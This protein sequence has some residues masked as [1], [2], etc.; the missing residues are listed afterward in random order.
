M[1][2]ER[3]ESVVLLVPAASRDRFVP[4]LY[5]EREIHLEEFVNADDAWSRRFHSPDDDISPVEVQISRL[6]GALEFLREMHKPASDFLEGL[7]PVRIL[8]THQ[9]IEEAVREV[10]PENL[11][12]ECYRLRSALEEAQEERIRLLGERD[13]LYELEF[14]TVR[15]DHLRNLRHLSFHLVTATGP[16]QKTFIDDIRLSGDIHVE[17]VAGV[18][19]SVTYVI[20]APLSRMDVIREVII[21]YALHEYVLPPVEGTIEHELVSINR[22]I[23]LATVHE[24]KIRAEAVKLSKQWSSRADLALGWWESERNRILQQDRMASS[25]HV[26]ALRGYMRA[27]HCERFQ[28]RMAEFFPEAELEVQP[29]PGNEDP[30]VSVTWNKF[31]RPAGLLVKMFGLPTYRSIDPTAFLTLT[32][33]IFFG[34]CY[35]D[36][37]YGIMLL[38]LASWLKKR[39]RG[40]KGLVEFFRL[41]TYAGVSTIIFGVAM[42]SWAADL[43]AYFGAGNPVDTLRIKF[44]LLDPMAKP[45]V[46]LGIAIGIGIFN[47]LYG[48]FLRFYRD[49]RRGDFHSAVYDGIFW[50]VYLGSLLA[51]SLLLVMNGPS[52]A[53]IAVL[54][55]FLLAAI[56]L[57][58]TQGRHEK[59]LIGRYITGVISLYGIMG[60]YG[61][62]AFIGDVISYSR[63]M[64]LGMTTSVVGMSFNIIAGMLKEVPYV[65]WVLF[66][67]M[68]IFGHIFNFVMSILSAFVHSARLIL[69]E[70][71]GRFYEGGGIPFSP[72]GF[73]SSRM[74]LI[75]K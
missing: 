52:G 66:F 24:D 68:V 26:F 36:L 44:T 25:D 49:F 33:L 23:T 74:E 58:L 57:V 22:S 37:L 7:F 70:W 35:G 71:F 51:L 73:Q 61:T 59:S 11:A 10:N 63:L 14:L 2:I 39:F 6:Q 42:G 5:Q 46:A 54:V 41:F 15:I 20:A 72:F 38:F 60:T 19:N 16:T 21:D 28:A 8:T 67:G 55:L 1:S 56:G 4:W 34:I 32:F 45:V 43:S 50:L 12:I 64:A 31:F 62:T 13:R 30:P 17:L 3:M 48:I 75:E 65:G 69:L 9:E 27:S 18:G 29:I 47:Q 53:K 40:Q